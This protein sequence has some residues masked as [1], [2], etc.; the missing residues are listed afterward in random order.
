MMATPMKGAM[1]SE[2]TEANVRTR[3][4]DATLGAN[5]TWI[6]A[7]D[8]GKTSAPLVRWLIR[9]LTQE[10]DVVRLVHVIP[11]YV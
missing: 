11:G 7:L 3:E 1:P 10:G 6:V 5:R 9:S 2:D 4:R 8:C